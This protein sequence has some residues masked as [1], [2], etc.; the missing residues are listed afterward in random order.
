MH[1]LDVFT[2]LI[3][4]PKFYDTLE[5]YIPDEGDFLALIRRML[6]DSWQI[7]RNGAVWFQVI[8]KG[9]Q[10]P[11]QGWKIHIS[12]TVKNAKDILESVVPILLKGEV[13]FKFAVDR[14]MLMLINSKNWYRGG[15]GK[16]ITIYPENE[17]KFKDLIE[18]LYKATV[19]FEGPY[20]LSDRRY[21]DSKVIYYRYGGILP[22]SEIDVTGRVNSYLIS[23][24]G[25]IIPD[26]RYPYFKLPQWV[27]DPFGIYESRFEGEVT[28]CEGRY[29]VKSALSFSNSGGVYLAEDRES[30]RRVVIKEARPYVGL[31][32]TGEDAVSLLKKEFRLLRKLSGSGVVPEAIDFFMDWEHFFLVEE[33]IEG[34]SLR[35]LSVKYNPILFHRPRGKDVEI[36]LSSFKKI[37]KSL[38]DAL[39][40]LH[41]NGIVFGDL[42]PNNLILLV[43]DDDLPMGVKIIDFEGAYEIGV[44]DFS[45][46]YT[47]GF[48]IPSQILSGD[49]NF[50][51]DY[52]ALGAIMLYY[53][54]PI[55]AILGVKPEAKKDFTDSICEDLG[56]PIELK[57]MI[58]GLMRDEPENRFSLNAVRENLVS[59]SVS[60]LYNPEFRVVD[61]LKIYAEIKDRVFEYIK[62]QVSYERLDRLFPSDVELFTTNPLNLAYGASGVA[63]S[64]KKATGD[65][66]NEIIDWILSRIPKDEQLVAEYPPGLYVGISGVAWALLEIGLKDVAVN[67][68]SSTFDHPLLYKCFDLFYGISGWGMSCLKFF[69]VL[70]DELYLDKAI[71]AGEHLLN[72][73]NSDEHGYFWEGFDGNVYY[74]LAH[75]SSGIALFLLYLYLATGD[76]R[77]LTAGVKA[78]EFDLNQGLATDE[79]GLTWKSHKDALTVLPYWRYGSAGVGCSVLRYYKYTGERKYKE[80]LEKIYI[81]VDRKYTIFPGRFIGLAG[82]GDFL[83]DMYAYFGDE[84]FFKS[85]CKVATGLLLFK[86]DEGNG[87]AFP[88]DN[89]FRISCDYGTGS[90]GI[91]LF[92]HRLVTKSE[93]DF[94]LDEL[95]LTAMDKNLAKPA[96]E[97]GY[98]YHR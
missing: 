81:D 51:R 47:P 52:Y 38:V 20:I 57:E 76:E 6:P 23:P 80:V 19:G 69:L 68:F 39:D 49:L 48:A 15:S 27:K 28:L 85:A 16:F 89:L 60:P 26:V 93:G 58:L 74:G 41:K 77:Y 2:Y 37:F 82:I 67:L 94:L 22:Y 70:G 50:E 3:V 96:D 91:G 55:N 34:I 92:F 44:D 4:D 63:Y 36:F 64:I 12:G 21:K 79:G 45:L 90:A 71:S 13:S 46:L 18:E 31:R 24:D 1:D 73:F 7:V 11:K 32:E 66:P 43:G 25:E 65:L 17:E 98:I 10:L 5:R 86:I 97:K 40:I 14:W 56:Y 29:V 30:G 9:I 8:P 83:L 84:I 42:S 35:E 72:K 54:M 87:V 75:G 53:L 88:G 61:D 59:L 33:Y 95:I 62:S 78:L